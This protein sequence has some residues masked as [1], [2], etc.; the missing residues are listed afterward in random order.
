M[1]ATL[2]KRDINWVATRHEQQTMSDANHYVLEL[3][4]IHKEY[5][6]RHVLQGVRL[7]IERGEFVAII[8]KS[9]C[10]KSTL[11]R[12][13][14][15]LEKPTSGTV[16]QNQQPLQSINASA[17][18]MFQNGRFLPWNKVID[19]VGIGLKNNWKVKA[20]QALEAV[21]LSEF[22]ECYPQQLSGGQKQRVALA[23]ALINQPDLLLLDEPLGALDA[24]TRMEMQQLI[25][26][27]WQKNN[28][29]CILVTHDVEEAVRLADRVILLEDGRVSH[30]TIISL[31]RPRV[32]TSSSFNH[33]TELLLDQLKI[34]G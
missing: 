24:L 8:G 3:T 34:N 20:S 7:K 13:I 27:V 26:D 2:K 23:R 19:N 9:G 10:G 17:R 16:R 5:G 11:L 4:D 30:E 12:L 33:Y 32:R 22:A 28:V 29:T 25:E 18:L 31:E 15:G 1:G 6:Q 21:G 14:A